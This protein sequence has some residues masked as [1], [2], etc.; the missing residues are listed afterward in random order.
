MPVSWSIRVTPAE[1]GMDMLAVPR[2]EPP[3]KGHLMDNPVMIIANRHS[4]TGRADF[5]YG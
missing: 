4:F 2:L 5:K 3:G 1:T